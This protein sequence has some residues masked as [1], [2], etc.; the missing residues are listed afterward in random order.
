MDYKPVTGVWEI[1]MGCNMRCKHCGSSCDNALPDELTTN[2]ALNLCKDLGKMGFKWI[3]LSGGEPTTRKDWHIIAKE[4]KENGVIP[5]IITNGWLINE[6]IVDKAVDAGVNTIAI[7]VDGLEETHDFIRKKGSFQRIINA[8]EII[9][10]RDIGLSVITTINTYNIGE[11]PELKNLLVEKGVMSWQLQIGLPMGNMAK[12]DEL[13]MKP[14]HVDDIIDFAYDSLKEKSINIQL[15]DCIGYFSLKELEVRKAY[16]YTDTE[17]CQWQGC[18]AG[19]YSLGILH[20]GDVLGCTSIRDREFIEG[21]IKTTPL[22]E[23][24]NNP[25]SFKWN[26]K[27]KKEMLGGLCGKCQFGTVCLGGCSNTKLT[28]KKN[29]YAENQYCSFNNIIKI[30]K[31]QLEKVSDVN[32]LLKKGRKFIEHDNFQL[33]EIVLSLALEKECTNKEALSLYGYTSFK[34]ENYNDS[35]IANEKVLEK[36]PDDVYA[37]KGLGIILCKLGQVE[38]GIEYLKKAVSKTDMNFMDPYYD[39]AVVL[40]E[41]NRCEEAIQIL[42]DGIKISK[43]F[44]ETS[45]ELYLQL[46]T[47]K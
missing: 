13:V 30:A 44:A 26:R 1:T 10:K 36:W 7:S 40:L 45:K 39:L 43:D 21:N 11:L 9:R 17:A 42:E 14:S 12:N 5:T 31:H 2:E 41:N 46:T 8:F 37:N 19:K 35:K 24:W 25:E 34:L 32:E 23:I 38:E 4:M 3:T 47:V 6:E 33:A 18:S 15:A 27:L 28:M 22:Q 16:S 29:I 20:N